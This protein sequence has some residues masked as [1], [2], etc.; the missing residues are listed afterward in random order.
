MEAMNFNELSN[1]ILNCSDCE[2]KFGFKPNPIIHGNENSKIIQ[3]SQA[4]SQN[5][6]ITK[7]PFDDNTGK[8]L[9]YEWYKITDEIF[10]DPSNFYITAI[11][12]CF[13]GK[14]SKGGDKLPPKHCADK[15][16]KREI[17]L[18]N[19]I[20][21]IIIGAKASKYVFPESDFN[22]LVF[23]NSLLN[24]KTTIVLPHPSPL[25]IKWFKDHPSFEKDR[26]PNIR[27]TILNTLNI[28]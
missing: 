18:V 11:A 16:L 23:R 24:G 4:P 10:Y 1:A 15:W 21:F 13:P 5:V 22:E 27:S 25:N 2:S 7:R 3:I 20:L 8:K 19:N 28:S 14:N 6:H 12:H 17:E 9:K 26:L